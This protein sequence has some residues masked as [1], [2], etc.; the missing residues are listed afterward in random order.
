NDPRTTYKTLALAACVNASIL[1]LSCE[2]VVKKR[3]DLATYKKLPNSF[4]VIVKFL[5]FGHRN[6]TSF[7]SE[8]EIKEL[9]DITVASCTE[10]LPLW[11]QL[12][13]AMVKSEYW[14]KVSRNKL[15]TRE[16]LNQV[17]KDARLRELLAVVAFSP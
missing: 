16:R 11:P 6:S 12:K 4:G 15:V 10:C 2:D 5:E 7:S 8:T 9:W 13:R 17:C 14:G 3:L 1:E